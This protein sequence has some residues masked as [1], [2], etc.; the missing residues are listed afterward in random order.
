MPLDIPQT[1]EGRRLLLN[2]VFDAVQSARYSPSI[3]R[4]EIVQNKGHGVVRY[5][6]VFC[7]EDYCVYFFCIKELEEVLCSK[8]VAN[9]FGGWTLGGQMPRA[10]HEEVA[11]DHPG[12]G[13]YSFN[14]DAWKQA[15]GQFSALLFS[16][17][18]QGGHTHVLQFDL[19]NFYD[20]VRLD[21]LERWIREET[22]AEKGWII[23][24]LFFFLN[25]WNRRNTGLHPQAVGLPMDALSDCS[26]ILA[27]YYLQKYDQYAARVCAEFDG[28]YFRYADDQMIF[29]NGT[30][31]VETLLMLLTRHLDRYGLR[32]NQMKTV[33]W[34]TA[35]LAQHRFID[36]QALFKTK[37]EKRDPQVVLQFVQKYL[38]IS[39]EELAKSWNGGIPLLNRLLY[40][41]VESLPA[42]LFVQILDRLTS[43]KYLI[44]ADYKTLM[45]I[46]H[47]CTAS[48]SPLDFASQ[49]DAI[50]KKCVH[51]AFH[52]EVVEYARETKNTALIASTMA[53]IAELDALMAQYDWL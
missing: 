6:P 36:L 33:I 16:Q 45:R 20:S 49:L 18:Q 46:G 47:L 50:G 42:S 39:K 52:Y 8:R 23:A 22:P 38:N 32:V 14:P 19:S 15:F 13:R 35:D 43:E 48:P 44:A 24:L 28:V 4:I 31:T 40:A 1:A 10:E 9:T 3:P 2:R 34:P 12:Y 27:N 11:G 37:E 25:Q 53:R 41:N 26:R 51:N 7:I 30:E 5:V 29:L 17:L 21:I